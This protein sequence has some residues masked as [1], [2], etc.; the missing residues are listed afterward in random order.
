[1]ATLA[2]PAQAYD[3]SLCERVLGP[4][5]VFDVD[6][7]RIDTHFVDFGDLPHTGAGGGAPQG[8]AVICWSR[9]PSIVA[10]VGRGFYDPGAPGRTEHRFVTEPFYGDREFWLDGS[11]ASA[12]SSESLN[13]WPATSG[14]GAVLSSQMRWLIDAPFALGKV[15]FDMKL[16]TFDQAGTCVNWTKVHESVYLRGD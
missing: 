12:S 10:G 2:G 11:T 5:N 8:N 15:R 4:G 9:D 1:V 6:L 7:V 13:S 14:P 3:A 16:C